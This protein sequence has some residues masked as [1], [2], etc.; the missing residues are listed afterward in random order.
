MYMKTVEKYA[1]L[2][3]LVYKNAQK[4]QF[5]FTTGRLQI[6][7]KKRGILV[8]FN[9]LCMNFELYIDFCRYI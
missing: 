8:Y 4:L 2:Q 9:S 1:L 6:Q 3:I 7:N 5:L